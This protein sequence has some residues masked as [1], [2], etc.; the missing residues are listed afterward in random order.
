MLEPEFTRAM[1]EAMTHPLRIIILQRLLTQETAS[2]Q[3]MAD[4]LGESVGVVAYHFRKLKQLKLVKLSHRRPIRGAFEHFYRLVNR[5]GVATMLWAVRAELL[6]TASDANPAR[7]TAV[8]DGEG[9]VE[10][11]GLVAA[12]LDGVAQLE[13]AARE[14]AAAAVEP[15]ELTSVALLLATDRG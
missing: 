1:V 14:R 15:H 10:L 7:G 9:M 5:D 11:Q 12:F 3:G 2:P 13:R 8:L 4:A 6:T